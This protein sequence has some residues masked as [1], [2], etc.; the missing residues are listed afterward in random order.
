MHIETGHIITAA[1]LAELRG[2]S[3]VLAEEYAPLPKSLSR[4][5]QRVLNRGDRFPDPV[6]DPALTAHLA[7]LRKR[8]KALEKAGRK[9]ARKG[10]R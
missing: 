9:A 10:N 8:R 1:E 6:A 7:K 4:A 5:A 2:E 3:R